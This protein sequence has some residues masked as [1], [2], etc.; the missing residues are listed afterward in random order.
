MYTLWTLSTPVSPCCRR[1]S[2]FKNS[3]A[4][5]TFTLW[6]SMYVTSWKIRETSTWPVLLFSFFCLFYFC[7]LFKFWMP[8]KVFFTIKCSLYSGNTRILWFRS[9]GFICMRKM[10]LIHLLGMLH[11]GPSFHKPVISVFLSFLYFLLILFIPYNPLF[12][13]VIR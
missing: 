12:L 6:L 4:C 8:A 1:W 2:C 9:K 7:S 5:Q 10:I 3:E 13:S 11:N